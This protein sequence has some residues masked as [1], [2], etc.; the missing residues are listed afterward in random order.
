MEL[1]KEQMDKAEGMSLDE[2]RA[3][4]IADGVVV[5]PVVEKPEEKVEAKDADVIDNSAEAGDDADPEIMIY[6]K[7]IANEDGTVDVYE[8]ESL[9]AL[10]DKIADG[11]RQAVAQMKK[12]QAEKRALEAKTA[13]QIEDENYV[14]TERLKKDPKAAVKEIVFEA[15]TEQQRKVA[16]AQEAQSRF[17]TTHPDYIANAKNGARLVAWLQAHGHN[18]MTYDGLE[19]AYQDLSSSGL[20]ELK[21]EGAEVATDT[22]ATVTPRTE[23]PKA[24][25]TQ[26]PSQ[27]R[28][29]SIRTVSRT[30]ATVVN[31]QPS[32]DEAYLMPLEKLRELANAQLAKTNQG[33]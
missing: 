24:E 2:L 25:V 1:T 14:I 20:L 22:N 33:A 26:R 30:A 19:K 6:R 4:A 8:A 5:E 28:S 13:Q 10:V 12:V 9:E 31:T 18:E 15:L 29:S 32:E 3:T 27:R 7:E 17:V 21:A 16:E 23:E 11:K